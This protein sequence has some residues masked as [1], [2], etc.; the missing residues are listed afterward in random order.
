M[1]GGSKKAW[2]KIKKIFIDIS[3][4]KDNVPAC[5]FFGNPGNG[6]LVKM[7]HNGIEYAF[8]QTLSEAY[9][10]LKNLFINASI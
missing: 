1:A 6:H 9:M 8:M 10:L 7:V 4:K 2:E 3:G 5:G